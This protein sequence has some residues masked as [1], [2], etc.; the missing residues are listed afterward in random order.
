[1]KGRE[2]SFYRFELPNATASQKEDVEKFKRVI[3]SLLRYEKTPC[4][5]RDGF[6]DTPETPPT[7][8]RRLSLQPRSPA[9]KWRL[10]KV[11]EPEDSPLRSVKTAFSG[12]SEDEPL[13]SPAHSW[14]GVSE[15]SKHTSDVIEWRETSLD[16]PP[17]GLIPDVQAPSR[18]T[19]NNLY[20]TT[21]SADDLNRSFRN[22]LPKHLLAI[23]SATAPPQLTLQASPPSNSH[24][25][26]APISQPPSTHPAPPSTLSP[27]SAD[28]AETASI[29]S[30][31]DSFYSATSVGDESCVDHAAPVQDFEFVE[32]PLR[33]PPI[34]THTRNISIGSSTIDTPRAITSG[35]AVEPATPTLI[36]DVS[37]NSD[38]LSVGTTGSPP[39]TIR[40]RHTKVPVDPFDDEA[41]ADDAPRKLSI[42]SPTLP[43]GGFNPLGTALIQKT[44]SLL[45]GPPAHLIALMLQIAARIVHR[46]PQGAAMRIPGAWE[47]GEGFFD[48]DDDDDE[49]EDDFGFPLHHAGVIQDVGMAYVD[50]SMDAKVWE[51]D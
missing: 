29:S 39:T 16:G 34:N 15:G 9:K 40:L 41:A 10:S 43:A 32:M 49:D 38:G 24:K 18:D 4:P 31:H 30:S 47:G 12:K 7:P 17:P 22:P 11:W 20:S 42:L 6:Q 36:S 3:A 48:D 44:Y 33:P 28:D 23:R 2:D 14:D 5:F 13:P 35:F 27:L 19:K 26:L 46:L 1:L 21:K 25:S 8:V 37:S 51:V 50:A 45:M